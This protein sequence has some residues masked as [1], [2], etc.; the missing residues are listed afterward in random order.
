MTS[1]SHR[2]QLTHPGSPVHPATAT[3]GQSEVHAMIVLVDSVADVVRET[4]GWLCD[5]V[6]AGW[7]VTAWVPAD[8]DTTPLRIL[9]VT[10]TALGDGRD[11][12]WPGRRPTALA[13]GSDMSWLPHRI[14][15]KIDALMHNP[16]TE[17]TVWGERRSAPDNRLHD[18]QHR[19]ST[20]AIAFKTQAMLAASL[21]GTCGSTETFRNY[22]PRLA[23]GLQ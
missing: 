10:A 20:A 1:T 5:R 3:P 4:G 16:R 18:V 14:G 6:W 21:A 7:D 12:L 22:A 17:V 11:D 9:G 23:V 13:I 19:L 15:A 8:C 2:S